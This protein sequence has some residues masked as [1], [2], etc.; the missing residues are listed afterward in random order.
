LLEPAARVAEEGFVVSR[1]TRASFL[2]CESSLREKNALQLFASDGRSPEL[3]SLLKQPLLAQS[4]RDIA[5][6]GGRSFYE[7]G[8]AQDMATACQTWG[9]WLSEE[10]LGAYEAKWKAPVSA[11]FRN[12]DVFTAPPPSQG[13]ALLAALRAIESILSDSAGDVFSAPTVHLLVEVVNAALS[14]RDRINSENASARI[15]EVFLEIASFAEKF[16][17]ERH[18]TLE[19]DAR[20]IRK[21]DTAHLAVIDKNGVSVSLIQSLFYDFGTCIPV[22]TGGFTL[23]NRGAAFS[24]NE[25]H[26]GFLVP[27]TRPPHT[28][29]PTIVLQAAKPRYVLGCMGGDGQMQTQLQLL[30]DLCIFGLDPQQAVSRGRWY[31]DRGLTERII[32]EQGAVDAAK[33]EAMGH[34]VAVMGRFEEIMGHAQVIEVA[35]G[36][37]VLIGAADPRSDGYVAAY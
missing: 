19:Y 8:I 33:L 30:V 4:L 12:L 5:R 14:I 11:T 15:A 27:G 21:G 36:G 32:A 28:L 18:R 34:R 22:M 29:M 26:P 3:Y 23:Q 2:A 13:F 20:G 16:D 31:L 9:G 24:L 17:P 25:E 10:D 6:S 7:G 37:G 1:H 35:P